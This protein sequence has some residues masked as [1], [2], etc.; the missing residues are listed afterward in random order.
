MKKKKILLTL[1]IAAMMGLAGCGE[2][3]T[4]PQTPVDPPVV[5]VDPVVTGITLKAEGDK[6]TLE[7]SQT[8]KFTA[9]VTGEGDFNK[10]Y[11]FSVDKE[12]IGVI[13]NEGVLTAKK[14]GTVVVTATAAGD[15]TKKSSITITVTAAPVSKIK[16]V[17]KDRYVRVVGKV[18]SVGVGLYFVDDGT[19]PMEVY[20][21]GYDHTIPE[22]IALGKVVELTGV[23]KDNYGVIE[24]D[25]TSG[26]DE[27]FT[28]NASEEAVESTTLDGLTATD[29]AGYDA[30]A[31]TITKLTPIKFRAT[32][33]E[34]LEFKVDDTST[35]KLHVSYATDA[36]KSA[37]TVGVLYDVVGYMAPY[38][39]KNSYNQ[40]YVASVTVVPVPV[41]S[42][43]VSGAGGA[44]SVGLDETLQMSATV[45]P[46]KATEKA[47]T[48]SVDNSEIATI[49]ETGLLTG[50]TAGSVVVTATA[51]DGSGVTG[52]A[53]IK[54]LQFTD[55]VVSLTLGTAPSELV[56]GAVADVSVTVAGESSTS[57]FNPAYTATSNHP[58][59]A[60]VEPSATG[61]KITGVSAGEATI[62]VVTA[63][64]DANDHQITKTIELTVIGE[65]RIVELSIAEA[66]ALT[67]ADDTKLYKI[68]GIAE[69][70]YQGS[71]YI[72]DTEG[73][74]IQGY[75]LWD[76][77]DF[78]FKTDTQKYS[79][80]KDVKADP[81]KEIAA[82]TRPADGA[83]DGKKVSMIGNISISSNKPRIS[84]GKFIIESETP[85][86]AE[87][88]AI[89]KL[90][91][92]L[93]G[94]TFIVSKGEE[95]VSGS[96]VDCLFGDSFTIE[97]TPESGYVIGTVTVS[98]GY[99]T[100]KLSANAQ[101]KYTFKA[102]TY[103][104]ISISLVNPSSLAAKTVSE[105]FTACD[106][107]TDSSGANVV[108]DA[109]TRVSGTVKTISDK[110]YTI[111]DGVSDLVVYDAKGLLTNVHLEDTLEVYGNLNKR[112]GV[113]QI[114]NIGLM[115]V[116]AATY[117][118]SVAEGIEHGSLA[119]SA[120]SGS[121]GDVVTITITPASGYKLAT[122]TYAGVACQI[123]GTE[124][125]YEITLTS[126]GVVEAT[127]VP[128][129]QNLPV[130][131]TKT[132][133]DVVSDYNTAHPD[134]HVVISS[135]SGDQTCYTSLSLDGVVTMS[136]SGDKNCGS[137]WPISSGSSTYEWRL[138]QN[139][140]GNITI[141]AASGYTLQSVKI[142]FNIKNTGTL[143]KTDSSTLTSGTA[144]EVSG[145]TVTYTVGNSGSA[146]NGQVLVR[147]IEVIYVKN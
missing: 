139:K 5:T 67:E 15:T 112:Y 96:S 76:K 30:I 100:Q 121:Y 137:F 91:E 19:G 116:E 127:F 143:V 51:K 50:K 49:S 92:S 68:T 133:N 37:I 26:K 132:M 82:S 118:I 46:E 147:G 45:A 14:A 59:I 20:Y 102:W 1:G 128:A 79:T 29:A 42:I 129:A 39:T 48:W 17:A 145:N 40:L 109:F 9:T 35:E 134:G 58:E 80:F 84:N 4:D 93:E 62:S 71:F 22:D 69:D 90:P 122:L 23:A 54:V 36:T 75:K 107:L 34:G 117:T 41:T 2:T 89:V 124:T 114:T 38:H 47:V 144:D 57:K 72:A 111:T 8:L 52:T 32:A 135:G 74:Y 56:V 138:Y 86:D 126:S 60:K 70:T 123:D 110:S 120:T 11:T 94:G 115:N 64:T 98:H 101:G 104:D 103:N 61:V 24:F 97:I 105:A 77:G 6:T 25:A 63:G 13:S 31:K 95:A 141:T 33:L 125:S 65:P 43:T 113:C 21:G 44:T 119:L 28:A 142:T 130:T 12:D 85:T 108:D 66:A 78:N 131:V 10:Q 136:T 7:I 27:Y 81:D 146:T 73:H 99:Y 140:G 16:D 83:L 18:T 106:E 88:A 53:T 3:P 55:P 87:K